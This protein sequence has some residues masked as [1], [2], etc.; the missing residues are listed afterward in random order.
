M[1]KKELHL[2]ISG[3]SAVPNCIRFHGASG[4]NV[5]SSAG[6][7]TLRIFNTQ[8]EM[9]NKNLGKA[10]FNRKISKKRGRGVE[11]PLKMPP[12]FEFTSEITREKEWDNIAALHVGKLPL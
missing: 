4:H 12:I 10:S 9:F 1:A 6:D 2:Q 7:S 8:T 5:L 11:D 3:H